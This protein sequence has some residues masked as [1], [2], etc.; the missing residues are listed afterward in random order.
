MT[1]AV[2]DC[3]L[4]VNGW[5]GGSIMIPDGVCLCL[6]VVCFLCM[7]SLCVGV[8]VLFLYVVVCL[9]VFFCLFV[10]CCCFLC[11]VVFFCFFLLFVF[12]FLFVCLFV[13]FLLFVC[14][15]FLFFVV[16][17]FV[18]FCFV[19]FFGGGGVGRVGCWVFVFFLY[20]CLY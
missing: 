15:W 8:F 18:L 14:F 9:W 6:F 2:N 13:V 4:E 19:L 11:V 5:G 3:I 1:K 17:V 16:V 7:F 20:F 10:C 12:L